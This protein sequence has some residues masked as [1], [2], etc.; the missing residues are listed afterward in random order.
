[1][2]KNRIIL[3]R[4]DSELGENEVV[5]GGIYHFDNKPFIVKAW[6]PNMKFTRE[7][8]HTVPIWVKFSGLNFKYCNAKGLSKIGSL[9]GKPLMVTITLSKRFG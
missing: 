6:S 4:F 3:V 8:M 7:E 1:M 5:Q 2:L 9:V